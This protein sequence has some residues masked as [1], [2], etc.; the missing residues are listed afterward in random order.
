MP[1]KSK[2]QQRWM[3]AAAARGDLPKSVPAK[4]AAATPDFSKLPERAPARATKTKTR[5]PTRGTK[6]RAAQ[7]GVRTIGGRAG[8]SR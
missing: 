1:F 7:S 4:F 6:P 3:Y 5:L 8:G 2:S